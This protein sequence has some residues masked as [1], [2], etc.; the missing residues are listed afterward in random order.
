MILAPRKI[1]NTFSGSMQASS[2][3][4]VLSSFCSRY[5]F[6]YVPK[7]DFWI[8]RLY[9]DISNSTKKQCLRVDSRDI[10]DLGPAKSRTQADSNQGQICYYNRNK[11]DT[12]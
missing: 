12:S 10:N 4:K 2:I 9:F 11:R 1:F 5:N 6:N 7:R 8:N 3:V